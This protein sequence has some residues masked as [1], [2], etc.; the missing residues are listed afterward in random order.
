MRLVS[1]TSSAW[2][3]TGLRVTWSS[4]IQ[5]KWSQWKYSYANR[6]LRSVPD[7]VVVGRVR[8][9]VG[10]PVA[11][12]HWHAPREEKERLPCDDTS[13]GQMPKARRRQ[14]EVGCAL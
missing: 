9:R 4:T 13:V 8:T 7:P 12:Y 11:G 2:P 6:T 3:E 10:S 1:G 5:R 14:P